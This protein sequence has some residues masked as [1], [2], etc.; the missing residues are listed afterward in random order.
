M[1][2]SGVKRL[3]LSGKRGNGLF[4][5]VSECDYDRLSKYKWYLQ[6][7]SKSPHLRYVARGGGRCGV[8][9]YLHR[10]IIGDKKGC[11]V[12]HINRN[13]LDNRR[14]NLRHLT[15]H[16]SL[17]NRECH[18][19]NKNRECHVNNKT[20]TTKVGDKWQA[21]CAVNRKN[22]YLGT[23]ETQEQAHEAYLKFRRENT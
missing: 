9:V 13:T 8:H 21:Q 20:G 12:D 6:V 23:Y 2:G 17:L 7:D 11:Y 15:P 16:N 10:S 5:I 22:H 4:T 3:A 14:E 19:N 18:A 1:N